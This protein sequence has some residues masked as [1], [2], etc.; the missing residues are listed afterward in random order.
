MFQPN[1]HR[2]QGPR[3]GTSG[4]VRA[5]QA[6]ATAAGKGVVYTPSSASRDADYD[7]L[8]DVGRGGPDMAAVRGIPGLEARSGGGR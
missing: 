1:Q 2:A 7:R 3:Y 6:V 5:K 8:A 4:R